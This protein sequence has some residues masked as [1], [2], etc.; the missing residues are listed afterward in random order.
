[1]RVTFDSNVWEK[2]FDQADTE[3]AI[4]RDALA[5]RR[6]HGFV[7]E[8]AFRIEAVRK[9]DRAAYFAQ[10]HIGSRTEGIVEREG[11]PYLRVSIGPEDDHHPGL[12]AIQTGKLQR[13]LAAGVRLMRGLNWMWLPSPPETRDSALFVL[14]TEE[15]RRARELRQMNVFHLISTRGVGLGAVDSIGGWEAPIA[16]RSNAIRY[17]QACAEWADGE[18]AAAHI[19]YQ[20]DILCTNDRAQASGT[21]IFDASNR[22]WLTA[23]YGVVF[24]TIH[25]LMAEI[26]R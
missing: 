18:L 19:A 17:Q 15:E 8:A 13:A 1:M 21:S 11:R 16:N 26:A 2:I 3:Y 24:K 7:C 25:E 6:F 14:E 12:P 4:I 5:A 10:P 23:H 22:A 20:H 9:K